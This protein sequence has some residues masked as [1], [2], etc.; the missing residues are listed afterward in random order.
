MKPIVWS[1]TTAA[2]CSKGRGATPDPVAVSSGL[3]HLCLHSGEAAR[4][5][6][7]LVR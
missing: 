3:T 2:E 7:Q 6:R 4:R 5:V 1:I